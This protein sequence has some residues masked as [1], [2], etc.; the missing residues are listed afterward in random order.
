MRRAALVLVL[1]L[2]A[3][4]A[5]A[6]AQ[7]VTDYTVG[8]DHPWELRFLPQGGAL[9][10]ER[11]GRVRLLRADGSIAGTAHQ[12]AVSGGEGGMLGLELDPD[13]AANGLVYLYR[14]T[15]G[16][17]E[18]QVVRFRFDGA[19]LTQQQV[20]VS[21]IP[22][23]SIHNG[24]RLRIGPDGWL[25]VTTGD[26]ADQSVAQ[27][28][29]DAAEP[30]TLGGKILRLPPSGYR[31]TGAG[32]EQVSLGHRN[33]QGLDWQPGTNV[34]YEDEHGPTGE[35]ELNL[36]VPGG[37]YGWPNARGASHPSP[38][39]SPLT[40]YNPAIAPSGATFVRR[41]GSAWSGD[42]LV[43][44]LRGQQVRRAR[45]EGERVT[46]NEPL[47]E[48]R[49]GRLRSVVEGP[50][51]ALYVLTSN[52]DDG[53]KRVV[54]PSAPAGGGSGG[55]GGGTG[56]GDEEP[57]PG[58]VLGVLARQARGTGVSAYG[59][60]LAFSA[61]DARTRRFRLMIR[62]PG[63][64]AEPLPVPARRVAFD[65][66]L[67][68]SSRGGVAAVYSRCRSERA[69]RGCD[70]FRFEIDRGRRERRLRSVST[71]RG[72]E[73]LPSLWRSRIAFVRD[74]RVHVGARRVAVGG[75]RPN[76]LDLRGRA[77]AVTSSRGGVSELRVLA[78]GRRTRRVTSR[79]TTFVSPSHAGGTAWAAVRGANRLIALDLG[80]GRARTAGLDLPG[81]LLSAAVDGAT[82][83][84]STCGGAG[85]GVPSCAVAEVAR[86]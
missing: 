1:L 54:P 62:R 29:Y 85:D 86:P 48:G 79:T 19:T 35:D 52:G 67:G 14:T 41:E 73:R 66:D 59:G 45:F 75:R 84:A 37:N 78:P 17:G 12:E 49:Y 36:I 53:I 7:E 15:P 22:A 71:R 82:A 44:A 13:F 61:Y 3:S 47:F 24:G 68:P 27:Q 60:F 83:F 81:R 51:G 72:S 65:V 18:N 10:T 26:A 25:Y 50:D 4:V 28:P 77:L 76:G 64:R 57:R 63:A 74:G 16:P 2:T 69:R 23:S 34:L 56:S 40:V 9:V 32:L 5:P 8:L 39:R 55:G 20:I 33:P 38:F 70:V 58:D 11:P 30:R 43:A 21:G 46:V 80:T 6:G 42:Y 31:G